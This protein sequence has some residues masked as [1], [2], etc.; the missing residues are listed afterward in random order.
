[1]GT[2]GYVCN[3][4]TDVVSL[5]ETDKKHYRILFSSIL[6]SYNSLKIGGEIGQ[7]IYVLC[8]AGSVLTDPLNIVNNYTAR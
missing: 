1:M 4:V 5:T 8:I 6:V 7:G 2:R 3:E